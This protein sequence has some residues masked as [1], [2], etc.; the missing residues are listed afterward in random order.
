M[1]LR[2]ELKRQLD[3]LCLAVDEH[4]VARLI[5]MQE[6][7]LRWNR[8]YNLTAITDPFEALEKH[9][10]DSLTLLPYLGSA[11]HL[12]DIGSGAGF[13]ALPLKIC[14]ADLET[15]SVDA[16]AKKIRFQK[17][18]IRTLGL[19]GAVAWHGRAEDIV[20]QRF[21]ESG[22]DLVVA[23]AFASIPKLVQL[24]LPCLRRHGV[25]VAMKGPDGD[26]ELTAAG[27]D[28][29]KLGVS[30]REVVNLTLPVSGSSRQL[31]FLQ[32]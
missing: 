7:L 30:C 4:A 21:T 15:V 18:L 5:T 22:F 14:R 16:V 6:E 9:L 26:K 23:R 10:V 2:S 25:I 1:D 12:L 31:L 27:P 11:K 29:E 19:K 13:P 24:A 28:L 32:S 3:S 20:H 17:H 8:T